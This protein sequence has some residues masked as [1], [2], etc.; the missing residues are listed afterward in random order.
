L[1]RLAIALPWPNLNQ[2]CRL[3][4]LMD[5]PGLDDQ[6][7]VQALSGLTR[8]NRWSGSARILWPALRKL[9]LDLAPAP[10]RILDIATGAGDVPLRLWQ[11]GKRAGMN[12]RLA[13]CDRS[14]VAVKAA[15]QRAAALAAD[16]A[17]FQQDALAG[18]LPRDNDA[19]ICSL[20]LHHLDG[21]EAVEFLRKLAAAARR[22]V[23]INDL[24]RGPTG[25]ALAWTGTRILSRSP[26][27]H[28][29]G[30]LSVRAAFTPDET[31][32]LAGQAGMSGASVRRRWPCRFLLEW[33][34]AGR[35]G[36]SIPKEL[37]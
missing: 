33:W 19:L 23:L 27:V 31:L 10:M 4:E 26:I 34:K 28:I 24:A 29:D 16:V 13:G 12:L 1:A 2:R 6:E 35:G 14:P 37:S 9:R 20:F 11:L 21:P 22:L 36:T 17:F 32:V 15:Q 30:P 5:Q 8:I 18:E 7:H 3:P 25:Y